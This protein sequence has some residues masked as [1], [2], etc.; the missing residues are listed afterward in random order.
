MNEKDDQK[1][2]GKKKGEAQTRTVHAH[3]AQVDPLEIILKQTG[4]LILSNNYKHYS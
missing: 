1:I 2:A 4:S 3:V